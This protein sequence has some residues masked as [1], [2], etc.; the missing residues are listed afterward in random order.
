MVLSHRAEG[1][2]DRALR[3]LADAV[4]DASWLGLP[5][6]QQVLDGAVDGSSVQE[7]IR[8][9]PAYLLA[10]VSSGNFQRPEV[11]SSLGWYMRSMA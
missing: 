7:L 9:A 1:V 5:F 8:S 2:L 11:T 6:V 10:R 3:D 4:T